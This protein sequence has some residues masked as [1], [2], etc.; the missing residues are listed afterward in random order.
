VHRQD[1][2]ALV[3]CNWRVN[4]KEGK[5]VFELEDHVTHP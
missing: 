4:N 3:A 2:T 5:K 1:D